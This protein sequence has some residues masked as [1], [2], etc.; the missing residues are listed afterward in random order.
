MTWKEKKSLLF[1]NN[2]TE[3]HMVHVHMHTRI[4]QIVNTDGE[5]C[6]NCGS[7]SQA[8]F[9]NHPNFNLKDKLKLRISKQRGHSDPCTTQQQGHRHH[10][11]FLLCPSLVYGISTERLVV[12]SSDRLRIYSNR[13]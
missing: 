13:K 12:E 10:S 3:G 11:S 4:H 8:H 9:I 6:P 2:V 7:T 5:P 1:M